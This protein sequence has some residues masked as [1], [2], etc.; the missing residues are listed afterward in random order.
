MMYSL[1]QFMAL[2][3]KNKLLFLISFTATWFIRSVT[4]SPADDMM[5]PAFSI[6]IGLIT[7]ETA[8]L[9]TNN[10]EMKTIDKLIGAFNIALE[11]TVL[12][13]A[14]CVFVIFKWNEF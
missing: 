9:I 2:V 8:E 3:N 6:G 5:L 12:I 4:T 10:K 7:M 11:I 14:L 13:V 1:P